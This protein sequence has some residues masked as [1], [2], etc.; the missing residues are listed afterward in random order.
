MLKNLDRYSTYYTP[1]QNKAQEED[2]QG[3]FAGIGVLFRVEKD[4]VFVRRVYEGSPAEKAG[5]L[6]GDY[7][8]NAD[9][10]SLKDVK[11]SEVVKALKGEPDTVVTVMVDRG[12]EELTI[13][14]KRGFV[15]VPTIKMYEMIE[16]D[17]GYI[18]ISQFGS[19]TAEEFDKHFNKLI[20]D[21]M[22]GL[23]LDLRFNG[24]GYLNSAV[25][26]CSVFLDYGSLVVYKEGRGAEREDLVDTTEEFRNDIPII[27]LVNND[28]ASASEVIAACLRDYK[29][30]ILLGEKTFGKGSVQV[31]SPMSNGGSL[32]FTVAKY[33]S[34]G[35]YVIHGKGLEPDI[36]VELKTNEQRELRAQ[37]N[38]YGTIESKLLKISSFYE[39]LKSYKK[40][41]KLRRFKPLF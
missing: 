9:S 36:A 26:I 25:D 22:K 40:F 32:R 7:I 20:D 29:I 16:E 18:Y 41:L 5:I 1:N 6:A 39:R 35:G 34:P 30:A 15:S 2:L 19:S 11:S 13:D 21:G 17:I 28:S 12:E 23:I 31:I 3:R 8:T 4:G 10:V 38:N 27:L 37:V 33:F 24:G 14:I